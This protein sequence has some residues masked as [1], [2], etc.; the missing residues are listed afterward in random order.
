MYSN[1]YSGPCRSSFLGGTLYQWYPWQRNCIF[2]GCTLK[3]CFCQ[4]YP[5]SQEGVGKV[6]SIKDLA[7]IFL[8]L[9]S[10]GAHNIS[11]VTADHYLPLSSRRWIW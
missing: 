8:D 2:S 3:C 9:Q 6:I 1:A 4:N 7:H 10:Q 11:L 5:I